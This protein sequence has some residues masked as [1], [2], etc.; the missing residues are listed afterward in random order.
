MTLPYAVKLG[1]RFD[2]AALADDVERLR[3]EDWVP[4]FNTSYYVGDWSG[5][6]LRSVGGRADRLYPDPAAQD[7][8][9]DTEVLDRCPAIRDLLDSLSCEL[10][11][12][13]LLRLGPGAR[14]RE[15]RDYRLG[16]DDGE[17]RLHVPVVTGPDAEFVLAG[18]PLVMA[19]GE[20]WYV[21]VNQMHSVANVGSTQRVH[22]VADCVVNA[23]LTHELFDSAERVAALS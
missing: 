6:S 8:Y 3:V 19:P 1:L 11:A 7:P 18:E 9:G 16:F 17:V 23:W 14:V 4:H 2:A 5:T 12:V 15:H 21:N 20:C 13:R 22:L 10:T